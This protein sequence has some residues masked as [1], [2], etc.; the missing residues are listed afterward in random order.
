[1][2]KRSFEVYSSMNMLGFVV[3]V[4][5][6]DYDRAMELAWKGFDM[7]NNPEEFPEY[8]D[9]GYTEPSRELMDEAGIEYEISDI[10]WDEEEENR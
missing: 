7:W 1:M 2:E 3:T 4:N 9:L 10:D 6:E 5:A 8:Y